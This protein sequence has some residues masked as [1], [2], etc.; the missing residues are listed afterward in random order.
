M[1]QTRVSKND[2]DKSQDRGQRVRL[3]VLRVMAHRECI[4]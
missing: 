2:A 3:V 1:D 4:R